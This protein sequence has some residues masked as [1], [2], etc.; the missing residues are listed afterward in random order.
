VS[1]KPYK[2]FKLADVTPRAGSLN[3]LNNPSRYHNTLRYKDGREV[4]LCVREV[5]EDERDG[6]GE[7]G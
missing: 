1:S 7:K 4:L 6:E 2:G 5:Q 3:I